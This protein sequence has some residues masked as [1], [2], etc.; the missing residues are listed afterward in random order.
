MMGV[1][2]ARGT[3]ELSRHRCLLQGA[4]LLF[5]SIDID[6][7]LLSQSGRRSRLS[8]CLGE[9]R[10]HFPFFSVIMEL[11][12]QFLNQR[13]IDFLQCLLYGEGNRGVIDIL[14]SQAKVDE[15]L[16]L[17]KT[18]NLVEFFLDEVL[19]SLDVVVGHLLDV[20]HTLSLGRGE[21]AI[22]VAKPLKQA[23]VEIFQLR[24]R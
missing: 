10:Y 14:G 16:V 7:H 5:Q 4:Q 8:M 17:V 19:D 11:F 1:E 23:M 20:L 12:Y 24:Q 18:S 9:H 21:V 15:L 2:V 13:I 3:T 22:D 6:H